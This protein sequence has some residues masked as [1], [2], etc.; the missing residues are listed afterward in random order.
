MNDQA[1]SIYDLIII[2]GGPAGLSAAVGAGSE[3]I[4]TLLLD[5]SN[6][7]GGQAA[8]STLIENY[9]GFRCGIGGRELTDNMR[10][11]ADRFGT[12]MLA[13]LMATK[14]T[15]DATTGLLTVKDD[16]GECFDARSVVLATG[17]QYKRLPERKAVRYLGRGVSYGS[18][19]IDT[20]YSNQQLVVIGGANSAGQAAMHL[21]KCEGC[22]VHVVIRADSIGAKMSHYLVER[23]LNTPNIIVHTGANVTGLDGNGQLQS[24]TLT[25]PDGETDIKADHMFVMIGAS[26]RTAW[27]EDTVA[28]HR[29]YILTGRDLP[30]ESHEEFETQCGRKPFAAETSLPG[31]FAIGDVGANAVRRVAAAVGAGSQVVPDLHRHLATVSV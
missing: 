12:Q 9:A 11:Q 14:I 25:K 20:T 5:S 29:G 26:P 30:P 27:L 16:T 1:S 2:G 3:R 18:P 13:P 31:V 7:F 19:S 4:R 22:T 15:R 23:I 24:I 10:F 6:V 28:L 21:S 17:V 8:E